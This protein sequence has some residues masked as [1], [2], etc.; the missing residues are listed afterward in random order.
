MTIDELKQH[1]VRQI[2]QFERIKEIMPVTQNDCK[3]YEEHKLILQLIEASD[4]ETCKD[5]HDVPSDEM[6]LE[7]A[8][9]AVKDLRKKLA[10]DLINQKATTCRHG[11]HCEWVACDKCNHYEPDGLNQQ[12]C[13]DVISQKIDEFELNGKTAEIWIVKGK[14]Q[15]RCLGVIH[16]ISLSSVTSQPCDDCIS[17]QAVFDINEHHHGQMPNH[18]NHEIWNE[19]MDLPS[20]TPR[21]LNPEAD[22][23]ES[24][25]YC[26]ECDHIEMCSWYPHDGCE[27]R[28]TDRYN[29][30]Y[31]AAKREIALSGEYERAY[32]RGK[33]DAELKMGYIS[34]DDVMS[35]FDDFMCGDVDEDGM[36]TFLEM[37]KDKAESEDKE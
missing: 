36:D 18:V 5:W 20:V 24:K 9:Q 37:L 7:Q 14:L 17:R 15:I 23:E 25:A 29:A 34:I 30:G 6:T 2:T 28:K 11:G 31:N 35:V 19:I 26:A 8:R 32:E 22:R 27:W 12:P 4:Q 16:N 13:D 10:E 1:C 21:S 3:R 33:K